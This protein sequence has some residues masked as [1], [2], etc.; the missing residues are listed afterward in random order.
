MKKH[1]RIFALVLALSMV[2]M[3]GCGKKTYATAE[4]WY[5][6][7]PAAAAFMTAMV[8]A[9]DESGSMTFAINGN[10][11]VYG[12]TM[13][14]AVFGVDAETDAALKEYFDAAFDQETATYQQ[15][16][17]ELSNTCGVAASELSVR[18]EIFNPGETTPGYTKTFTAVAE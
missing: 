3:T 16:I 10:T 5:T 11:V 9:E 12:L 6:S 7:N 1:L 2:L 4:E 15:I 8:E 18:I 14:E 17:T 13:D